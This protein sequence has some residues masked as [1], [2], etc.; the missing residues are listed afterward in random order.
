MPE[1]KPVL[2]GDKLWHWPL[3][4]IPAGIFFGWL[5]GHVLFGALFVGAIV[6]AWR[7]IDNIRKGRL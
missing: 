1:K 3:L 6:P 7:K 4:I 5:L 2:I